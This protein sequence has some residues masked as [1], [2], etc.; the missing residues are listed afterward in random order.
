VSFED[1][2]RETNIDL[3]IHKPDPIKRVNTTLPSKILPK[4]QRGNS[5]PQNYANARSNTVCSLFFEFITC[6]VQTVF[7]LI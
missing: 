3:E 4:R 7:Q 1:S 5:S 6:P 2:F